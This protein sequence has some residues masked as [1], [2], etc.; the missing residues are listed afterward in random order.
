VESAISLLVVN[1]ELGDKKTGDLS[2]VYVYKFKMVKQLCLL[3]YTYD[4]QRGLLILLAVGSHEN[5][6]RDLKNTSI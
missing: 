6:Y 1:P 2:D 4:A 5:F 3:A